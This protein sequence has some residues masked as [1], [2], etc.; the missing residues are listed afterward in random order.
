[1]YLELDRLS[2]DGIEEALCKL[3]ST[4]N[5][6]RLISTCSVIRAAI[7][8]SRSRTVEFLK[9]QAALD[10]HSTIICGETALFDSTVDMF[11]SDLKTSAFSV[12][13]KNVACEIQISG[14]LRCV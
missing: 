2:D 12:A 8:K 9:I 11:D 6:Q 7:T 13:C 14:L 4:N 5:F 3:T 1:M 10:A